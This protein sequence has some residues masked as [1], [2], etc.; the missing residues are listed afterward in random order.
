VDEC[1]ALLAP[2][3]DLAE[4]PGEVEL[5]LWFHDAVYDVTRGD[6]EQRSA[7]WAR[8][9][10]LAGG[11]STEAAQRLHALVMATRHDALPS[12]RDAQ[13]LVDVDLAILGAPRARFD[14]YERQV[15]A[16]YAWVPEPVFRQKRR[17]VLAGMLARPQLYATQRFHAALEASARAN[18]AR[19]IAQLAAPA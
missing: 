12:T 18:L 10:A 3:L 13:L 15:R 7:D 16:E 2:A 6:N 14:D 17:E 8:Q 4:H 1:I 19:S 11:V 5:A 9:A